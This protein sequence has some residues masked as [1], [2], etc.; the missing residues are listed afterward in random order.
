MVEESVFIV[1]RRKLGITPLE[2]LLDARGL[3][4]C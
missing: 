3:G 1:D 4:V 2:A